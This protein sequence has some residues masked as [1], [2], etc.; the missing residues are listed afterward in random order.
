MAPPAMNMPSVRSTSQPLKH[1]LVIFLTWAST[2]CA[3]AAASDNRTSSV[4]I[5]RVA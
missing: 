3:N 1:L 2:L 5:A 4:P